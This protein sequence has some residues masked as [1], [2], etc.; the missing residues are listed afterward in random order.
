MTKGLVKKQ[1]LMCLAVLVS[2]SELTTLR[3]SLD[4]L[5]FAMVASGHFP[6]PC[7]FPVDM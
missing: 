7:H 5:E 1:I 6:Y 3:C 4:A 2:S